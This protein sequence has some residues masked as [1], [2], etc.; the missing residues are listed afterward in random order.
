MSGSWKKAMSPTLNR[1]IIVVGLVLA[2]AFPQRAIAT[3]IWYN[4]PWGDKDQITHF[5][6]ATVVV[7][8]TVK[9]LTVTNNP[10]NAPTRTVVWTVHEAWKGRHYKGAEFTTNEEYLGPE[11]S[12]ELRQGRAMLLYLRGKEPYELHARRC[13]RSGYLEDSI[14]ALNDLFRLRQKWEQGPDAFDWSAN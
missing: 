1:W 10:K 6:A 11:Y 4:C 13:G 8:A 14:E 3:S 2:S 7:V 9:K 5:D 12:W